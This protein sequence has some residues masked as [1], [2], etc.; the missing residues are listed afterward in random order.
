VILQFVVYAE[1]Y[2]WWLVFFLFLEPDSF[3]L[4]LILFEMEYVENIPGLGFSILC[5]PLSGG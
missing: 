5:Y 3:I 1:H 2:R 4:E